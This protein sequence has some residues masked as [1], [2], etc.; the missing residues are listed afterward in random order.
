MKPDAYI[1]WLLQC[2]GGLLAALW[3]FG[4]PAAQGA[5]AMRFEVRI[6]APPALERLLL[7]H[8]DIVKWRTSPRMTPAEWERLARTAPS[9]IAGLLATEGYFS[10]QIAVTTERREQAHL[11]TFT[12]VPGE[13][14][15]IDTVNLEF[16]GAVTAQT[17]GIQPDPDTLR[18]EWTLRAGEP[19]RQPD[20]DAAKQSLLSRLLIERYPAAKIST[21]RATVDPA[22]HA[23]ALQIS[24][25]SGPAF[26]FGELEIEGLTRYPRSIVDNLNR[27]RPGTP[28]SQSALLDLQNRLQQTGYFSSVEVHIDP[29]PQQAEHAP[30]RVRVTEAAS[31]KIGLGLGVSTNTGARGQITYDDKNLFERGW[32]L[33]SALKLETRAQ[34]LTGL[35]HFPATADGY[36][37]SVS[38][39]LLRSDIEGEEVR[40]LQLGALRAWGSQR[41]EHSVGVDYTLERK[42]VAGLDPADSYALALSYGLTLRR[43]D[44][45]IDPRRGY[46]MNFR[47]A[48]SPLQLAAT[49]PFLQ[50]QVK[51]QGYYPLAQRTQ[52]IL[53]AEAGAVNS[54]SLEIPAAYLFRT[55]GDQSVRG[56]AY[57]SL[58]VS[59]GDAVVGG[60]YLL[61]GS[62]EVVQW[63]GDHWGAAVFYDAGNAADSWSGL[64]PAQGYGIGVRWRSPLGPVGGD[65]AHGRDTGETRLHFSLGVAF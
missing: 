6:D 37:D 43:I 55:G 61:A 11:A 33:A 8:L 4:A 44:S 60:R 27:I 23:A 19:F 28:Y 42:L 57:Q 14:T 10:P 22:R 13:R 17:P 29:D 48:G 9:A 3:L 52:L 51:W 20:W 5:E 59:R 2:T 64:E 12:V 46:L 39:G 36:R 15:R 30:V 7:D 24:I 49:K 1:S 63:L 53:R 25:D 35:V 34:S 21:S 56:Y 47:F 54:S 38:A 18:A 45:V 62:A 40:T 41:R 32:R 16:S 26:S 65:L 31:T 58:G 50:S